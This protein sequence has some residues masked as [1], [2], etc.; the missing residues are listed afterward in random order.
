MS[1]WQSLCPCVSCAHVQI[2]AS[3]CGTALASKL[4]R[5]DNCVKKKVRNRGFLYCN[6]LVYME[7]GI[8]NIVWRGAGEAAFG[9]IL[10]GFPLN[11][12]GNDVIP[13]TPLDEG[14]TL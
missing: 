1:E 3:H 6:L 11:D 9:A 14:G 13:P 8:G 2:G 12:F 10:D 7:F 5:S 4:K